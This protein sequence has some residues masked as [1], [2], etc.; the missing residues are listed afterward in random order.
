MDVA[1]QQFDPIG[2]VRILVMFDTGNSRH[3]AHQVGVHVRIR[4]EEQGVDD[5]RIDDHQD[6]VDGVGHQEQGEAGD[7]VVAVVRDQTVDGLADPECLQRRGE[8]LEYAGE[9]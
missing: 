5:R 2:D 8:S 6:E 9:Q 4:F 1:V 3:D 7:Q